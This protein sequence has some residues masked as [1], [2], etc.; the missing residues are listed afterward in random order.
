MF[1]C[2]H[3][4]QPFCYVVQPYACGEFFGPFLLLVGDIEFDHLLI[5]FCSYYQWVGRVQQV[6]M[7]ECVLYQGNEYQGSDAGR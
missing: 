1:I 2:I 4:L 5:R 3:Q 6:P 7:L